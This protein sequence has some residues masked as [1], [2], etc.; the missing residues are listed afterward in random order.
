MYWR[1]ILIKHIKPSHLYNFKGDFPI[2]ISDSSSISVPAFR[3]VEVTTPYFPS[4]KLRF[5]HGDLA[6]PLGIRGSLDLASEASTND[7]SEEPMLSVTWPRLCQE[8]VYPAF[9]GDYCI[10]TYML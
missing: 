9:S 7:A 4:S 8:A 2:D 6:K 1:V 5:V 10:W 3:G